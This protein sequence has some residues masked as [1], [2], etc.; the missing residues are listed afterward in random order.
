M[1]PLH[2]Q[3][4]SEFAEAIRPSG[5][6]N[7]WPQLGR[8][9]ENV[10]YS[11]NMN[12]TQAGEIAEGSRDHE[13][14]DVAIHALTQNLGLDPHSF[15]D[16]VKVAELLALRHTYLTTILDASFVQTIPPEI[17]TEYEAVSNG[18]TH[19]LIAQEIAS[20]RA[21]G[22]LLKP[23]LH[24]AESVLG[25]PTTERAAG[26]IS[27]GTIVSQ[28]DAFSI[29]N[30]GDGVIV[31]HENR[32]LDSIPAVGDDVT[33]AYYRGQGQVI[34]RIAELRVGQPF[35][36][37]DTGDLAVGLIGADG[38]IEHMV[39]FP[40]MAMV[41]EFAVEHDMGRGFVIAAMEAR[42]ATPKPVV[43]RPERKALG[44]PYLDAESGGLAID[45]VE[46]AKRF[47][48]IFN[49]SKEMLEHTSL[50][51]PSEAIRQVTE[52]EQAVKLSHDQRAQHSFAQAERLVDGK[53]I[54]P[55][56]TNSA[57]ASGTVVA[58]TSAHI[59]Q[60]RGRNEVSIHDKRLLDK[61]PII[62]EHFSVEYRGGRG[63]VQIRNQSS[64]RDL[65]R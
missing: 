58:I 41:H 43:Q 14:R 62:G 47:T 44:V 24:D 3:T 57:R 54:R 34:E 45:Y 35:V 9:T 30:L 16:N 40:N 31:A 64:S 10:T 20:Q 11:V 38:R 52:L 6:M 8:A 12:G 17:Q 50:E 36:E 61:I 37:L 21:F 59:V 27:H 63:E 1:K 2:E 5:G 22:A 49:S 4:F 26:G 28:N 51:L 18:F 19:P 53:L 56:N 48:A 15:R 23:A 13:F 25:Q 65:A 7:R 42:E 46:K 32:R 33:V 39:M 60:D 55:V 29:Q